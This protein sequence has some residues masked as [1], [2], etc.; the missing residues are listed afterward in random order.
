MGALRPVGASARS[1]AGALKARS[2][3]VAARKPALASARSSIGLVASLCALLLTTAGAYA[4]R[5]PYPRGV[6]RQVRR[7][8]E[9]RPERSWT[10]RLWQP[11]RTLYK[12]EQLL[13]DWSEMQ[14][15]R[16]T[17][18]IKKLDRGANATWSER[19]QDAVARADMRAVDRDWKRLEKAIAYLPKD[20]RAVV[21]DALIVAHGAHAGQNRRS[22]EPFVSHPVAVSILLADL[23]MDRDTVVAGLLHD[24]V[25]DTF[26]RFEDV[27][28]RFG[29]DVRALVEGET[30]VSKLPKLDATL[31]SDT[32]T[33]G[34]KELEQLENLRQMFVAMTDDYR[35][36]L[37]RNQISGAPQR[38]CTRNC[39]CS[40]A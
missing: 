40:M 8:A 9:A 25:E 38:R 39:V 1:S 21:R 29:P 19:D 15:P 5:R 4:P 11:I 14:A 3:D 24:T 22:G 2:A 10:G 35:I 32:E 26:L 6:R 28:R 33:P 30:K 18:R 17:S 23:S 31:G 34:G 7:A 16:R 36:I 27:E 12:R 37:C 13:D 20:E